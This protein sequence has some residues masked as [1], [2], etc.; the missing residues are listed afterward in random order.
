MCEVVL[1]VSI[2]SKH[3]VVS[4]TVRGDKERERREREREERLHISQSSS[5]D[6]CLSTL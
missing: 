4:S 2:Y 6:I 3:A 5:N 1:Y